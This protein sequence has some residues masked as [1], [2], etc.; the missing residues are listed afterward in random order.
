MIGSLKG[1]PGASTLA[2]A[3]AATWPPQQPRP[4]LL[5]ADPA[6]GQ[7]G[8]YWKFFELPGLWSLA[9]DLNREDRWRP[10]EH[11]IRL[12]IGVDVVAGQA[13]DN[14]RAAQVAADRAGAIPTGDVVIADVGRIERGGPCGGF[15]A[16][17][18]HVI[19]VAR[20]VEAELALVQGH[21]EALKAATGGTMWLATV[22]SGPFGN[23]EILS[24]VGLPHLGQVPRD[25]LAGPL[26]RGERWW[27][28]WRLFS[29][30]RKAAP[31]AEALVQAGPLVKPGPY[32]LDQSPEPVAGGDTAADPTVEEDDPWRI[33]PVS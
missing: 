16:A 30:F 31:I 9:Q 5:E 19:V 1:A 22:G 11:A 4:V 6:G 3:L 29:L 8:A 20:P 26:L 28:H 14:V 7:I 12:P 10:R 23:G 33:L 18:D 25:R 21:A 17:A 24:A 2:L 13:R 32:D 27:R 15:L